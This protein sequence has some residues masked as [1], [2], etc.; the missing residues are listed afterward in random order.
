[1]AGFSTE[2]SGSVVFNSGSL[3]QAALVP[4]L[5]ALALT[6]S[7]NITGSEFT[8]NGTNVMDRI[9]ALEA[10]G[11][12]NA[13]ILPLN[14]HSASINL[15]TGSQLVI[16]NNNIVDSAS[17]DSRIDTLRSNTG[18]NT[19]A[20]TDLEN[21]TYISASSQIS[22][23][24]FI[25][26]SNSNLY[27]SSLQLL[28]DGFVTASL[29]EIPAGTISSSAQISVLGYI[30]ASESASFA[31]TASYISV[32]NIDGIVNT[33]ISSS[34]A[35]T[36]S[37][38]D[39]LFISASA[40]AAGFGEGGD[41]IPAGTIS[42]SAQ[43]TGLGFITSSTEFDIQAI[44]RINAY[45]ASTNP[46]LDNLENFSSS[47]DATYASDS[48][49]TV[50]SSSIVNTISN[51]TK[52]DISS[53]NTFTSSI[54]N[55]VDALTNFSS[56]L[57]L[58]YASDS[59]VT[60]LSQS[61]HIA[62]L[63]ITSSVIDTGSINDRL[64]SLESVTGSFSTGS[65]TSIGALNNFTASYLTDSASFDNRISNVSVDTSS[66]DSRLDDLEAATGS[67]LTS[68]T[69]SQTISI[70]GDQ[71]TISSGNT[72]TIPSS[73]F[74]P[75]DISALNAYTASNSLDSAS[76]DNRILNITSSGGGN[77]SFDGSR[78]IS[79][80]K[81]GALFTDS[82]NPGTSTVTEFLD[83]VFYPNSGP[84]FTN[85][86]NFSVPEFT[87]N[88]SYLIGTLTA[89]D[90]EGQAL[91]FSKGDTYTDN[92]VN[93]QSNGQ[94]IL[95]SVPTTGTFNTDDRGD[96]TLAHKVE[97]KVVDTF[98]SSATTDIYIT[99]IRNTAPKFRKDSVNGMVINGVTLPRTEANG[100]TNNLYRV[101][102]SDTEA[103][104]ITVDLQQDP[105]GHFNLTQVGNYIRLDQVTSS[106]DYETK[107]NYLMAITAS[108][109]HYEAG[110]DFLAINTMTIQVEVLDNKTPTIAS[111]TLNSISE[112][113]SNGASVDT[114]SA[115]DT[116][117]DTINF[118]TFNQIGAYLDNVLV[119]P[120]T[121]TGGG[122]LDPHENPFQSN[123][124]GN[125]IRKSGVF[126]NSDKINKYEYE[127]KVKDAYN[128]E[129]LPATITIPITD[130]PAPSISGGSQFYVLE[131]ALG[132]GKVYDDGEG[133]GSNATRF[134]SNQSV[135]WNVSSSAA[136]FSINSQ[137][138][139][140][141]ARDI[142][143]SSDSIGSSINGTVTATNS[144]GT[145]TTSN[146]VV[147]VTD[148]QGPIIFFNPNNSNLNTNGAR[149]GNSIA[150]VT[151]NDREGDTIDYNSFVLAPINYDPALITFTRSGNAFLIQPNQDL[152]AG[153]YQF[154]ISVADDTGYG[155]SA[156]QFSINILQAPSGTLTQNGTPYII[157]SALAGSNIVTNSNG[158]PSGNRVD[159]GVNYNPN[160]KN[161][162]VQSFSSSNPVIDVTPQGYL[163]LAQNISGS[164]I[165]SGDIIN[166][167]IT[168]DD[169]YGNT[170]TGNLNITVTENAAPTVN[171]TPIGLNTDQATSGTTIATIVIS[172]SESDT[173][174]SLQLSGAGSG[175][176][177][178]VAKNAASSSW[179]LVANQS[180]TAG[181]YS[182]TATVTDSFSKEGSDTDILE[183]I[184]AADFGKLYIYTSTRT[185]GGTLG[186]AN[187]NGIMGIA[188]TNSETPPKVTALT[189]DTSSP[190]YKLIN[191]SLGDSSITV[192]GG[193]LTR[194]AIASG[195]SPSEIIEN[196][197]S[198]SGTGTVADQ[199]LFIYPSGSDMS[200][201]PTD[202]AFSFGGS[203]DGD[204]V[205]NIND[206]GGFA[207]TINGA[208]IN[209]IT[210]SS[211]H[212]GYDDWFV[213]G[214]TSTNT[215]LSY[216]ARLTAESGSAPV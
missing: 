158:I 61:A 156:Y 84:S 197:G 166:T 120:G 5:N 168:Y 11:T 60:S 14:A 177:N 106:L 172:D 89:T 182:I 71:L 160:Y 155:S 117:G 159:L 50:L 51:L 121:Y 188:S 169:Q 129:S 122:Q 112:N 105:S 118:T 147:S 130:D 66:L 183:V 131:S 125:V 49:L 98:N 171:I 109:E 162:T 145:H 97:V 141:L 135:T 62:R 199:L 211:A 127:V 43:I 163:S 32:D 48:E 30:T 47:L 200:G 15:Y 88:G 180:I 26:S 201:I 215:S 86:A 103:D 191:G 35:I 87:N 113:S 80:D 151:F 85:S 96:G 40:A 101:Y 34:Y 178:P 138:Y 110:N 204:Y 20:I 207:N 92:L 128:I 21:K 38:I 74:T 186:N 144:F 140:F 153:T 142:A 73:S 157:E 143:G 209:K 39:P 165:V 210:L 53:L 16:N 4:S 216:V 63:N 148:N 78:I 2:L 152:P 59:D 189:A 33:S 28:E 1:M 102:L 31:T 194:R 17:F 111:Q 65:H 77:T 192:G 203:D 64:S 24:G 58:T 68:E 126:I 95:N 190:I 22:D 136:D 45:T 206:A 154:D 161:A 149:P 13:S 25:S 72:I 181:Q 104:N 195:S 36:A 44:G 99:S 208:K 12:D 56:S 23:F 198:F 67:Y 81:L 69:D 184:N 150:T 205:L 139:L 70:V 170:G 10:G 213:L 9:A 94:I 134:T 27:S 91:T 179:D 116:E 18:T 37:Y 202:I 57:D 123:S 108:D 19:S 164:S 137:G 132:G 114:I 100:A 83:A 29:T 174:Y 133:Y 124:S 75:T 196:I 173:P 42:S 8:F 90:P 46:R 55:E 187:Y 214:R 76:F 6:G 79:N 3:T 176:V 52:T 115:S 54:Q 193:V 212:E 82:V 41:I 93:I 119:S 185:G 7:F 146:F 175:L 167:T 107:T